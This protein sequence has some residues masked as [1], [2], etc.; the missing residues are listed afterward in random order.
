VSKG[1]QITLDGLREE[2]RPFAS[3]ACLGN[4]CYECRRLIAIQEAYAGSLP[5]ACSADQSPPPEVIQLAQQEYFDLS[6]RGFLAGEHPGRDDAAFIG[7]EGVASFQI[8]ADVAKGAVLQHSC[9]SVQYQEAGF[10]AWFDGNLGN[11]FFGQCVIQI[12]C[13]HSILEGALS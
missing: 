12:G 6:P 1:L 2:Q 8:G 3:F 11:Q 4:V 10:I 9:F 7:Y 13:L 5:C